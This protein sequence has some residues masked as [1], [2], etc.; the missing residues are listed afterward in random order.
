MLSIDPKTPPRVFIVGCSGSG[1]TSVARKLAAQ[2]SLALHELDFIAWDRDGD[3]SLLPYETRVKIAAELS[4]GDGWVAEGT[5][6][7][8]TTAFM[9]RA[10]VIV[11]MDVPMRVA[12]WRVFWRHFRAELRRDNQF[13]GWRNLF[14]FMKM[15][16]DQY[17]NRSEIYEPPD[18]QI[19]PDSI[20][21][22]LT[23]YE[24]KVVKG[25]GTGVV[26]EITATLSKRSDRE[27]SKSA[28]ESN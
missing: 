10:H 22:E 27:K 23:D 18:K 2:H 26:H 14:R 15:V 20:R 21:N 11:W 3:G 17:R 12:L 4:E 28:G 6:L 16:A 1:K 25:S 19:G 24:S 5:Y 7:G 9:E 13:P 8:W